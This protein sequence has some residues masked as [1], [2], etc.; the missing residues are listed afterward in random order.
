L[1]RTES[2]DE[3][4]SEDLEYESEDEI[5]DEEKEEPK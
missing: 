1:K 4:I 3:L 2:D 5:D